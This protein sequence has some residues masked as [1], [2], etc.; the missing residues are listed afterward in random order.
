M[1]AELLEE[2][3]ILLCEE[4]TWVHPGSEGAEKGEIHRTAGALGI[5]VEKVKAAVDRGKVGPLH[6]DHWNRLDNAENDPNLSRNKAKKYSREYGRN[7]QKVFK[8]FRKGAT[9][10]VPIVLH[11]KGHD[12]YLV[13][14]NTRLMAARVS[15]VT[16]HAV[17]AY[18]DE[19][20]AP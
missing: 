8:G 20:P 13:G 16:P 11:R 18:L 19:D 10:P 3:E 7:I 14:G 4:P 15:G 6:P 17:H 2:L 1:F 9:M 5:P 12:P